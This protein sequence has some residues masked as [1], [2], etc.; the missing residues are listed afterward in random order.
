MV[1]A[2]YVQTVDRDN[3]WIALRK[4]CIHPSFAQQFMD[5]LRKLWI[6]ALRNTV[7]CH[8]RKGQDTIAERDCDW[9]H[10]AMLAIRI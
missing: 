8:K 10:K 7:E 2:V 9:S 4:A 6:H 5:C 3:P 1:Y